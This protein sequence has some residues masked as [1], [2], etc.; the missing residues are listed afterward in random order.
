ME[1]LSQNTYLVPFHKELYISLKTSNSA[2]YRG[3]CSFKQSITKLIETEKGIMEN[4]GKSYKFRK[5]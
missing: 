1:V 5:K 3:L 4:H 2:R